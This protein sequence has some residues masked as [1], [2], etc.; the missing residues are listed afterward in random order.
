M[1]KKESVYV[2]RQIIL[3]SQEQVFG[4]ELLFRNPEQRSIS[5]D[6]DLH[7]TTEVL[8][9]TMNS[10]GM[11]KMIGD[12]WGFVNVNEKV[13]QQRVYETL[14]KERF[15]LELLESTEVTPELVKQVK[16][17]REEGYTFAIDDFIFEPNMIEAFKPLFPYI[18]IIK[19]D[20]SSNPF[21]LL[22]SSL[23]VVKG[24]DI[25]L[26]AEKVET[27]REF[28]ICKSLGFDYFQGYFF[29][30]P[31]V[32]EGKRIQSSYLGLLE[33]IHAVRSRLDNHEVEEAFK[34]YPGVTMN[35][36]RFMNS[37]HYGVKS[38]KIGSVRHAI[39]EIGRKKLIR[40]L[41]MM[42]YTNPNANDKMFTPLLDLALQRAR[43]MESVSKMH[44]DQS[45]EQADLAFFTGI[46]SLIDVIFQ[47]P[48]ATVL[49]DLNV[50]PHVGKA[51]QHRSGILGKLLA[52]VQAIEVNHLDNLSRTMD[53]L[54][55]EPG[56]VTKLMEASYDTSYM[57][58]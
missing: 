23:G 27:R 3:D 25:K 4:Y 17:M 11:R 20:L 36:L 21:E 34:R 22:R 58:A 26:L 52:L 6:N 40:W 9:N 30:R 7:A 42:F 50:D 32:M 16:F 46:L 10:I 29:S 5:I 45:E 18:S 1:P 33:L 55:L 41:M 19:V 57:F 14:E 53:D 49:E 12:K 28:D 37:D 44:L 51:I 2:A 47:I 35:L 38:N 13:L 39:D 24:H 56:S 43:L 31:E 54:N 48:M 8:L 15:I